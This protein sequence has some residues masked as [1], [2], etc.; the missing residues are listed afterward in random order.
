MPGEKLL[1]RIRFGHAEN[2][3]DVYQLVVSV[4]LTMR[5]KPAIRRNIRPMRPAAHFGRRIFWVFA[6]VIGFL[7]LAFA[8]WSVWGATHPTTDVDRS[9]N[10]FAFW[11]GIAM[12]L[13]ALMGLIVLAT[14]SVR[15]NC[16]VTR[17]RNVLS[18]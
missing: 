10:F 14:R 12:G 8:V 4:S 3:K 9:E 5:Q 7:T 6:V 13:T 11:G 15:E 18:G 17:R 16:C 2:H 1:I